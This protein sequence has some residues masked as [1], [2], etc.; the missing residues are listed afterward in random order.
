MTASLAFRTAAILRKARE[1]LSDPR[2]WIK[3]ALRHGYTDRVC[4]IGAVHYAA[5]Y[6][7]SPLCSEYEQDAHSN[8]MEILGASV[9]GRN[10]DIF[11][12]R[13]RTKHED[14]LKVFDK[15]IE[16]ACEVVRKEVGE[17]K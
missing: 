12:D 11:N 9:P 16:N 2:K 13:P 14:V 6:Y 10:I 5:G 7:K 3:G 15:A 1:H 4:S 17:D 8:A